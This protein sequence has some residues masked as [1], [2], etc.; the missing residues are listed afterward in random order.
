MST[1]SQIQ[2]TFDT[3]MQYV[4]QMLEANL[5][6]CESPIERLLLLE[7]FKENLHLF[8]ALPPGDERAGNRP[9]ISIPGWNDLGLMVPTGLLWVDTGNR[10]IDTDLIHRLHPQFIIEG[11]VFDWETHK[12]RKV[13]YRL[14]FAY[15]HPMHHGKGLVKIAIECDGH[16]FHEKTK[17]Q[18]KRDKERDRYLQSEGW[19]VARFTGSEIFRNP[20]KVI[21]E[22]EHL[23]MQK[24][25]ELTYGS[26]K[27]Q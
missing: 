6:I 10:H 11:D 7:Y 17:E 21:R 18:A 24:D 12:H 15:F 2:E 25:M 9:A 5:Q 1:E 22:I 14:D 19:I 27:E 23:A 20:A 13:T 4:K 8:M 26:D 3:V 16:E